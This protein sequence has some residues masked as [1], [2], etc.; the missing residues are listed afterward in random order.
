M[1]GSASPI[2]NPGTLSLQI[3]FDE[4]GDEVHRHIVSAFTEASGYTDSEG[5]L[6]AID[7]NYTLN[8]G[9]YTADFVAKD[10]KN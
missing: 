2:A 10:G 7:D 5:N 1:M 9:M 8:N 3:K 6:F 4:K